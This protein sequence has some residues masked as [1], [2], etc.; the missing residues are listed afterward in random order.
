[1]ADRKTKKTK[2]AEVTCELHGKK[3]SNAT[4][5]DKFPQVKVSIAKNRR[6]RRSGCPECG[7]RDNM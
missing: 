3:M 7:K 5:K 4:W 6:E 2:W 1:M